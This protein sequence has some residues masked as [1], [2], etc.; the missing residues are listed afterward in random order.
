M[1]R[2]RTGLGT[3]PKA[4]TMTHSKETDHAT[5]IVDGFFKGEIYR[6]HGRWQWFRNNGST[7][8]FAKGR[9]LE[10]VK[11]HIISVCHGKTIKLGPPIEDD[12]APEPYVAADGRLSFMGNC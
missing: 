5:V 4:R 12:D 10:F 11:R 2:N 6:A 3:K 1:K 8:P 9:S 7:E